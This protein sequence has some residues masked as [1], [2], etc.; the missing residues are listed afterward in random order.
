MD[1]LT[2]PS[3][4]SIELLQLIFCYCTEF[5]DLPVGLFRSRPA[6]IVVSH[7]CSSWRGAA[8]NYSSLWTSINTDKMGKRWIE[9]FL[10]RS[11][12]S[13]IDVSVAIRTYEINFKTRYLLDVD[14]VIALFTGCTRL[15]SLQIT[16]EFRIIYKLLDELYTA[17]NIRSL[18]LDITDQWTRPVELHDNLFGGRAPIH[19]MCFVSVSYIIAPHW[20]L[21]GITHFT[22]NQ[23]IPLQFLLDT[24]RQ[25]AALQSFTLERRILDWEA[26]DSPRDVQIPMQNLMHLKVDVDAGSPA[27]FALLHRRLAL[28]NGVKKRLRFH[29]SSDSYNSRWSLSI[30]AI[31]PFLRDIINAAGGL[32]HVQFSGGVWVGSFL[33]WTGDTGY[34]ETEFLFEVSWELRDHL[35]P[36]F[37]LPSFRVPIVSLDRYKFRQ[38]WNVL[39]KLYAVEELEL[40]EDAVREF[41]SARDAGRLAGLR[42]VRIVKT[43]STGD[44]AEMTAE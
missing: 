13:P 24:L 3:N 10:E 22:S 41:C 36:I 12:A 25:M 35:F 38:L 33:L 30:L 4:L 5:E 1:T 7:V 19:E 29:R 18:S 17:T 16:G 11:K 27:I 23:R 42:S 32:Q 40:C 26:S 31:P 15:R 37:D 43:E 2:S 34:E 39:E 9:A 6:W 44:M 28:P 20:L 14:E 8:L 21:R